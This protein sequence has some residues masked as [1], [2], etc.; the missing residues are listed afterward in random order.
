L[1]ELCC[2]A[3]LIII[4]VFVVAPSRAA[5]ADAAAP[6]TKV[7]TT[8]QDTLAIL[9]NQ[10]MPVEQR[11]RALQQLAERNLDIQQMARQSLSD[12]W[13]ELN[14]ADRDEFVTL[15]TA[16]IEESYL[17]Q[18]QNYAKL[19]IAVSKARLSSTDY[20]EVDASVTQPHKEVLPVTF[21]LERRGNDWSVYDVMVEGISMVHN[22]RT[23]FDRVIER[24]GLQ[25]LLTDLKAKQKQLA[26]LISQP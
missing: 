22:Y 13:N 1:A 26:T 5:Q 21:M 7:K 8:L 2:A 12:H 3:G 11:R 14:P 6:L 19:D 25:Q 9:H 20:A 24:Q 4:T 16:F 18:I 23:Q 17:I 15:F 10:S